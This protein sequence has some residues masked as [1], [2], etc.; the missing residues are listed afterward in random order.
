MPTQYD[1]VLTIN[2]VGHEA[3]Y[4]LAERFDARLA[5]YFTGQER[6]STIHAGF[7]QSTEILI[8]T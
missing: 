1:V 7:E 2:F 6:D 3:S 4:Y 5:L 8:L